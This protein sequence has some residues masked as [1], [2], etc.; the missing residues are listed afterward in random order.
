MMREWWASRTLE[1]L[2]FRVSGVW[3]V[4]GASGLGLGCC[5]VFGVF[6]GAFWVL[7]GAFWGVLKRNEAR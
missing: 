5:R 6:L 7:L 3:G 4:W 1:G 2:G